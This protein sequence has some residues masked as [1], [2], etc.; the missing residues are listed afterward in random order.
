MKSEKEAKEL[1]RAWYKVCKFE[2][3]LDLGELVGVEISTRAR[4]WLGRCRSRQRADA[5]NKS[6]TIQL[7]KTLLYLPDDSIHSTIVHEICHMVEGSRQHDNLWREACKQ[8]EEHYPVL[9]LTQYASLEEAREFKKHLPRRKEYRVTCGGCGAV[10]KF[11]R[12]TKFIKDVQAGK[13]NWECSCGPH[14][15]HCEE[16][17][18]GE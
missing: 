8:V 3:G 6:C 9:H 1:V 10:F 18:E 15:F 17:R 5:T 14:V 12:K 16:G 2:I 7:A 4:N 13:T 11:H